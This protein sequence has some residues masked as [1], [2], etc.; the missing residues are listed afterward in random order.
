MD[1]SD[2]MYWLIMGLA[3]L[4]AV[5]AL[6]DPLHKDLWKDRPDEAAKDK[7]KDQAG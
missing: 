1:S 4:I 5:L 7:R 3:L 2:P 6:R